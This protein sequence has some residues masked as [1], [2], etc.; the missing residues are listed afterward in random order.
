MFFYPSYVVYIVLVF[1][2]VIAF[3]LAMIMVS[4][5]E[6]E[7]IQILLLMLHSLPRRAPNASG[8]SMPG[9]SPSRD[10][11]VTS[12]FQARHGFCTFNG[13]TTLLSLNNLLECFEETEI[14]Q[15]Q[16]EVVAVELEQ[17][18]SFAHP[19]PEDPR[20]AGGGLLGPLLGVGA[21]HTALGHDPEGSH[22]VL[23][24]QR[25]LYASNQIV[26]LHDEQHLAVH[27]LQHVGNVRQHQRRVVLAC[28]SGESKGGYH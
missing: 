20:G 7:S 24:A 8:S 21:L 28:S 15:S 17:L 23:R 12:L 22:P 13:G 9:I 26:G 14:D 10:Y 5:F 2:F 16:V 11:E 19:Q 1:L 6:M 18:P 25:G 3:P 4:P 27:L